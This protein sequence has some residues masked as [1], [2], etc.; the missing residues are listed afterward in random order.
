MATTLLADKPSLGSE[1]IA[2][3]Q[4]LEH[5][6]EAEFARRFAWVNEQRVAPGFHVVVFGEFNRGK[7]TLIN[8]LL[9]REVLPAKLVPTTG[10]VTRILWGPDEQV[11]V[12]LRSGEIEVFPLAQLDELSLVDGI[13]VREDVELVEVVADCTLLE[14]GLVFVDTP[15]IQD[16]RAQSERTERALLQADLILALLDATQLLSESEQSELLRIYRQLGTPVVPI[17]NRL[18]LIDSGGL[19]ELRE[20]LQCWTASSFEPV[21]DSKA[22][23]EV[24]A[25]GALKQSLG[26]GDRARD[27]FKK[28]ESFLASLTCGRFDALREQSRL[29]TLCSVVEEIDRSNTE[30]LRDLSGDMDTTQRERR[31]QKRELRRVGRRLDIADAEDVEVLL[32]ST[33]FNLTQAGELL[34]AE[35]LQWQRKE[36]DAN[37]PTRFDEMLTECVAQIEA[38]I[39]KRLC[40]LVG[41]VL[42]EP[43]PISVF[44]YLTLRSR[45]NQHEADHAG[46]GDGGGA[47]SGGIAGGLIGQIL[48]PIP[49]FGYKLGA[50]AG[51]MVGRFFGYSEERY[52]TSVV[53]Q[54]RDNWQS[55]VDAIQEIIE[56]EFRNRV[57]T[58]R[59][60]IKE[61]RSRLKTAGADVRREIKFRQQLESQIETVRWTLLD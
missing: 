7:S 45:I 40:H 36:I 25:L 55:V 31:N 28:L 15:G 54:L 26:L 34:F 18:N 59:R 41:N 58:V 42:R 6:D 30:T 10:H 29:R 8:A 27:D 48:I 44:E 61:E 11:R 9:G 12:R 17:V 2:M 1:L 60:S 50:L 43:Q 5:L 22:W 52:V 19:P 14:S 49:G 38:E 13:A 57:A 32:E 20:R 35:L 23:F 24:D 4:M 47:I 51:F 33:R 21:W 56:R 46:Y 39:A 53:Q 37:A 16:C 3:K